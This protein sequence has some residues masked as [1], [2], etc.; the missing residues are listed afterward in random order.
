MLGE[1]NDRDNERGIAA[2]TSKSR[3]DQG[4]KKVNRSK[5]NAYAYGRHQKTYDKCPRRLVDMAIDGRDLALQPNKQLPKAQNVEK[6]Y[7]N[8]WEA[9]NRD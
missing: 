7:K 8:L 4:N 1:D 5:R 2:S 9:E 6:L 3:H